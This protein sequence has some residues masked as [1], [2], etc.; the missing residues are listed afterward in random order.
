MTRGATEA[1][2]RGPLIALVLAVSVTGAVLSACDGGKPATQATPGSSRPGPAL[3]APTGPPS[4]YGAVPASYQAL[5]ATLDGQLQAYASAAS[6]HHAKSSHTVLA[7][8]LEAADGNVMHPG[9]LNTKLLATSER[10]VELMKA[11][12]ETGVTVQVNFPLLVAGFPD[13]PEYMTFYRDVAQTVHQA[14]M[15]LT[16]EENPLFGNFT[17]LPIQGYYRGLDLQSYAAADH[18][19]AQTIIDVMHPTYLSI[20]TEPDTY[21]AVLHNP[22]INLDDPATGA[23]F[24]NFVLSGLQR[25][26]TLVGAGTGTWTN[27]SYDRQ[28]LQATPIDYLDVHLYPLAPF[29]I[30][31]MNT[32]VSLAR[33]DHK[34]M[35]MSECWLYKELNNGTPLDGVQAAPNEQK[36]ETYSFWEPLDERFLTVTVDYA[37][38][39]GF[40]VVSPFS[41][42]NFFAYQTW[43]PSLDAK[44]P[45]AVRAS[46]NQLVASAMATGQ[47][48]GVGETYRSLAGA[49]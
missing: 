34:P 1:S 10:M 3:T 5:Y 31:N 2:R 39:E 4:T 30:T 15:T 18:Q 26:R 38:A 32:Q 23:Q 12:G 41:T 40:A 6:S 45:T 19:M 46:F 27:P 14:G 29:E 7:S 49:G 9:V 13:S 42:L 8:A 22:A 44:S 16:V 24:V 47:L 25:G 36:I 33:G 21:T 43:S 35:L 20:L 17:P 48:S 28:L 11:M 37:R